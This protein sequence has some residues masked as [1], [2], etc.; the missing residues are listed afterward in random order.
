MQQEENNKQKDTTWMWRF[1]IIFFIFEI[2]F[3]SASLYIL[4][5]LQDYGIQIVTEQLLT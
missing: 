5:Q 4:L 3:I 2:I 1:I